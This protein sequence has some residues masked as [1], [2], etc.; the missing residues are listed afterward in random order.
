M[1]TPSS[2]PGGHPFLL[3]ADPK[4]RIFNHPSFRVMGRSGYQF[5]PILPD[6]F[7]PLPKGSDLFVLPGRSPVGREVKSETPVLLRTN[8]YSPSGKVRAVA[9]FMAPGY[10]QYYQAA[11]QKTGRQAPT[12]PLFSY[13]AVGWYRG[14]FWVPACRIDADPRQDP[15]HFIPEKIQAGVKEICSLFPANRLVVHLAHCA[16][17]YGCPAARNLFLGCYEAPLPASPACNARCLGCI[18]LQPSGCCPSTQERIAFVPSPQEIAQIAVR[19]LETSANPVVSFGQGCEGEPLLEKETLL[20][21]IRLIRRQTQRGTINLN[22]NGSR[23]DL[24]PAL[25]DAG[26]NS[27]RVSLNSLKPDYYQ[28]YYRPRGFTLA[29]V[30][31]SIK[32]FKK[33]GGFTSINYLV[34]PGVTDDPEEADLL[35]RLIEETGLDL[36]QWRNLNMDPDA[37][38]T[39]INFRIGRAPLGMPELLEKIR[40][41]FPNLG[42][43]YFNRNLL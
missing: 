20:R 36:I 7:I 10:T 23:P 1:K 11:F 37:Y 16:Q 41:G 30:L 32:F 39:G 25:F 38:L 14:Q 4:G 2:G 26:L 31:R 33:L 27:I 13:T 8:P 42:F 40:E 24:L 17:T 9:A 6:R 22:T 43:G 12:L 3:Y 5:Y 18:S 15:D 35:V 34:F 21:A 28:A 19:H 29:Q